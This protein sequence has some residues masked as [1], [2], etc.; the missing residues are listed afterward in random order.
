MAKDIDLTSEKW[1]DLIFEKK[2][3]EYG[4]YVMRQE[5]SD[6]HLKALIIITVIGL[7]AIYLPNLIKSVMPEPPAVDQSVVMELSEINMEQKL[8]EENIIKAPEAA[9][10]PPLMKETI[11][12]TESEIV[13]DEEVKDDEL[14]LSQQDLSES[15]AAISVATVE[16]VKSGG[17]DIADL[18]DHKVVVADTEAPEIFNYVEEMPKFVG[19]EVEMAKWINKNL[20]YPNIA[21]EQNIQGTVVVRFVVKADGSVDNVTVIKQLDPSLDK[22][23][24]RLIN[25]MPKWIPGK[26][27]GNPVNV[28]FQL[29]IRFK[30][31][32]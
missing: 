13:K 22:E 31:N 4:A 1:T 7:T 17:V 25:D 10:P 2:N 5:S 6:R 20:K 27:N 18:A 11:K 30:L 29:P 21:Q 15:T 28:Y 9:P 3:K 26:Q 12:F 8:E 14:M 32:N 23:A 24:A 16:G 19:G